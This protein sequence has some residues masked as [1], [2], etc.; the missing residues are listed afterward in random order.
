[1]KTNEESSFFQI[2]KDKQYILELWKRLKE[3]IDIRHFAFGTDSEWIIN[4]SIMYLKKI[5]F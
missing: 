2:G 5:N 1:M 4:A 3:S